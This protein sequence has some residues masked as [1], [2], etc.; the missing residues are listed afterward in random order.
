LRRTKTVRVYI[1]NISAIAH[2]RNNMSKCAVLVLQAFAEPVLDCG[3][4]WKSAVLPPF[5]D[6]H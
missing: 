1:E 6:R 4:V 3:D 2:G 5:Q